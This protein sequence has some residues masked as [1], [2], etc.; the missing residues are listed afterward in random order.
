MNELCGKVT[1]FSIDLKWVTPGLNAFF[2][3]GML[4]FLNFF[5]PV[6][7]QTRALDPTF[8]GGKARVN[9]SVKLPGTI[10]ET[11]VEA[12]L[13]PDGKI[14]V[15][16]N[17]REGEIGTN[18]TSF[19]RYG[20]GV[21]RFLPNGKLDESFG[22]RGR[23]LFDAPWSHFPRAIN[24][25]LLPDGKILLS[26]SC[27]LEIS[28]SSRVFIPF[29]IR[30]RPDGTADSSFGQNG[31]QA[32][33]IKLSPSAPTTDFVLHHTAINQDGSCFLIGKAFGA[34]VVSL[35]ILPSGLIDA[36]FGSF[37]IRRVPLEI[38]AI[39]QIVAQRDK[40][41]ILGKAKA[42]ERFAMF[43]LHSDFSLDSTFET[44]DVL[45]VPF[46]DISSLR[47]QSFEVSPRGDL[48]LVI[49]GSRSSFI[50]QKPFLLVRFTE[51][52]ALVNDFGEQG[53]ATIQLP[54]AQDQAFTPRSITTTADGRY[55]VAGDFSFKGSL[56][57]FLVVCILPNGLLDQT[58]G[59][60][61]NYG[62]DFNNGADQADLILTQPD[63]TLL[64]LGTSNKEAAL[65]R[66]WPDGQADPSF[67][68]G[69]PL[70][71]VDRS[72]LDDTIW[73]IQTQSD[74]KI[75]VLSEKLLVR[76][77]P[78]GQYDQGFGTRGVIMPA[79]PGTGYVRT[80]VV[81]PDGKI[82]AAGSGA[83][84]VNTSYAFLIARYLPDGSLDKDF[85]TQGI[86]RVEFGR[87]DDVARGV[88]IQPDGKIVV[89]GYIVTRDGAREES[90]LGLTRLLP[91][92]SI[93]QTFGKEGKIQ[94][95]NTPFFET[96]DFLKVQ[97]DGKIVAGGYQI[98]K[99][100]R[101]SD[102]EDIVVVRFNPNG[103]LD[104]GFGTS[105]IS[106]VDFSGET[107]IPCQMQLQPDGKILLAGNM[108]YA[109]GAIRLLPNGNLDPKFGSSGKLRFKIFGEGVEYATNIFLHP[110]GK[111]M[112]LGQMYTWFGFTTAVVWCN[113]NG[114]FDRSSGLNALDVIAPSYGSFI[115]PEKIDFTQD[116]KVLVAGYLNN[117]GG[118]FAIL[119]WTPDL[120]RLECHPP[121]ILAAQ[122]DYPGVSLLTTDMNVFSE[123]LVDGKVTSYEVIRFKTE[124]P[125]VYRV[126]LLKKQ[127]KPG[128]VLKFQLRNQCGDLSPEF[129]YQY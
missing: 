25:N 4:S 19:E 50:D 98:T 32:Y 117:F 47:V 69:S 66:C 11:V 6:Q 27:Y 17:T 30:L 83:S 59:L 111:I 105:G 2:L 1:R 28:A 40:Y 58:F 77:E 81:Q 87:F 33:E 35:K 57:N 63:G 49:G 108:T 94:I 67:G 93:D 46:S 113:P 10:A 18:S 73:D 110:N 62:V 88:L 78:D 60:G 96:L 103:T 51:T 24:L 14:V 101:Y 12:A 74:G 41:V 31:S 99:Y 45:K 118:P 89:C 37:G 36:Q 125:Q 52:G 7:G 34:Y 16:F 20:I 56:K 114:S 44:A 129:S 122:R 106:R 53:I 128:K 115:K 126:K 107:D 8:A 55:F 68:Q 102:D 70:I 9:L 64:V 75:L 79:F 43:R 39:Y 109:F 124:G 54:L 95:N 26:G 29:L 112:I 119:R 23:V 48:L 38:S 91:N 13:Q 86:S 92:G 72:P 42:Q 97:Q 104:T 15:L 71:L 76:L 22:I 116:G 5:Q 61:G 82:L 90:D 127:T 123:I 65:L 120:D 21:A 121:Q 85:G 84:L 3:M 100:N 80:L